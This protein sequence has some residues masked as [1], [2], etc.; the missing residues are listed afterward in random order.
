MGVSKVIYGNNTLIDL[1]GDTVTSETLMSG[2]TAHDADGN[3]G[4]QRRSRKALEEKRQGYHTGNS[5]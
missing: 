2:I 5:P 4:P 3:A 1:S